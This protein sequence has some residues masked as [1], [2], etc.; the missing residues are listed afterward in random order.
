MRQGTVQSTIK[1][2]A[3]LQTP[4]CYITPAAVHSL[5][6]VNSGISMMCDEETFKTFINNLASLLSPNYPTVL[7]PGILLMLLYFPQYLQRIIPQV[8][9]VPT[10]NQQRN[11]ERPMNQYSLLQPS[12]PTLNPNHMERTSHIN[13]IRDVDGDAGLDP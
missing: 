6:S 9:L 13:R 5:V 4:D 2:S 10:N 11:N 7:V 12:Q 8:A 1:L 3:L